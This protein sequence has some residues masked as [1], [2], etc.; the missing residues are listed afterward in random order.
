MILYLLHS[1][2]RFRTSVS[3]FI[4]KKKYPEITPCCFG[5]KRRSSAAAS[6]QRERGVPFRLARSLTVPVRF[7]SPC[8][9][10]GHLCWAQPQERSALIVCG[11]CNLRICLLSDAA[12]SRSL[13][14][15]SRSLEVISQ[16]LEVMHRVANHLGCPHSGLPS[17]VQS[18]TANESPSLSRP[19]ATFP[20]F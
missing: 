8:G 5:E 14:V 7:Y 18:Q 20:T 9:G 4:N 12:L 13:E 1:H 17:R 16:S 15:I 3:I 6:F 2:V 10:L 19:R 11:P